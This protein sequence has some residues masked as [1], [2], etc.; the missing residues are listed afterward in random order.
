VTRLRATDALFGWM[1]TTALPL[2]IEKDCQFIATFWLDW[3]TVT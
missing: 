1:K 2:S 3:L